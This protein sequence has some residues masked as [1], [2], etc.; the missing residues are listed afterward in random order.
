M[1]EEVEV[2]V[3]IRIHS[4]SCSALVV[5]VIDHGWIVLQELSTISVLKCESRIVDHLVHREELSSV[6]VVTESVGDRD[7]GCISTVGDAHVLIGEP[8]IAKIAAVLRK[9]GSDLFSTIMGSP[10]FSVVVPDTITVKVDVPILNV[11]V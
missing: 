11:K 2:L 8:A 4:T 7:G 6:D 1:R 5:G 9:L 3:D 10:V